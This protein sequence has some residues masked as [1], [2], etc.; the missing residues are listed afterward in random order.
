MIGKYFCPLDADVRMKNCY[1]TPTKKALFDKLQSVAKAKNLNLG[2]SNDNMPNKGWMLVM[3]S[4]LND[5]DQIFKKSY[6]A[7]S[8]KEKMNEEKTIPIKKNMFV[9]LPIK[10]KARRQK[11]VRLEITKDAALKQKK[12]RKDKI[13]NQIIFEYNLKVASAKAQNESQASGIGDQS[14]IMSAFK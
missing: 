10:K 9:D 5:Q 1:S 2:F 14:T 4:T 13:K 7:P 12:I 8:I 6:V 11:R 3:L